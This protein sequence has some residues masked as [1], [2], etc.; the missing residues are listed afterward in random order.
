MIVSDIEIF[1][2]ESLRVY[3]TR[4][5]MKAPDGPVS[6][7]LHEVNY[8]LS[9]ANRWEFP[10]TGETLHASTNS[11][12]LIGRG[13]RH[14]YDD[15]DGERCSILFDE[16]YIENAIAEAAGDF[17]LVKVFDRRH[18]DLAGDVRRHRIEAGIRAILNEPK[19]DGR[20]LTR[21]R[22]AVFDIL[23][24]LADDPPQHTVEDEIVRYIKENFFHPE[25][26]LRALADETGMQYNALSRAIK[27]RTGKTFIEHLSALR[28]E[29]ACRLLTETDIPLTGVSFDCGFG[30]LSNFYRVFKRHCRISPGE[31]R[32]EKHG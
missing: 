23:M 4:T 14:R 26:S 17:S 3:F 19:D 2:T 21:V 7:D 32:T 20:S 31:Y 18:I 22:M 16:R 15:S 6:H 11:V 27:R 30:D 25:L 13:V 1:R 9:G 24:T 12:V 29:R 28:I 8:Y 5:R 10:D